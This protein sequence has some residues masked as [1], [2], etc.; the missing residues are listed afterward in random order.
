MKKNNQNWKE[1][2]ENKV[3]APLFIGCVIGG[4]GYV[5]ET[6]ALIYI[7]SG[8]MAYGFFRMLYDG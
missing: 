5:F 3:I 6:E 4:V 1:L 7:G 8:I 2:I